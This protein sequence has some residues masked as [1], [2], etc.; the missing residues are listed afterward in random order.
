MTLG[1]DEA[2]HLLLPWPLR[3]PPLQDAVTDDPA[4]T[5]AIAAAAAAA[6]RH[7]KGQQGT[8]AGAGREPNHMAGYRGK[9]GVDGQG[10]QLSTIVSLRSTYGDTIRPKK[11]AQKGSSVGLS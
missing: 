3:H 1:R 2:L 11:N 4:V 7:R 9:F 10:I 8:E 6:S 5:A